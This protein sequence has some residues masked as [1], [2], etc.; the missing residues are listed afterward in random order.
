MNIALIAHDKKKD[1]MVEFCLA[2]KSVLAKHTLLATGITGGLIEEATGLKVNRFLPGREGGSEQI[3]ARIAYNEIDMVLS[4]RDPFAQ[5]YEPD[6][7]SLLKLCD[8]HT[9]PLATNVATAEAL[10]HSLARGD[11]DYRTIMRENSGII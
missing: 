3:A 10:I 8:M 4:F 2:Y 11:L 7:Q 1:L 9:V 5:S 6:M